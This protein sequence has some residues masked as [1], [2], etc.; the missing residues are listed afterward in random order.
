MRTHVLERAR[1]L[2]VKNGEQRGITGNERVVK[3][4]LE[5]HILNNMLKETCNVEGW[6]MAP[7]RAL[8]IISIPF[9]IKKIY[10]E[11]IT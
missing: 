5:Y 11:H 9:H 3:I 6:P 2:M 1:T 4:I 7:S 10:K 8:H